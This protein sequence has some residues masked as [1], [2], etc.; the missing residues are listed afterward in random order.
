MKN[1]GFNFIPHGQK[2]LFL[3]RRYRQSSAFSRL[4]A[5]LF[6]TSNVSLLLP[7]SVNAGIS[8]PVK[9][10]AN[11]L[12]AQ[13]PATGT[14][15]FV[16]PSTGNDAATNGSEAAPYKTISFALRQA[17]AGSIIQLAPGN[18][19][20]S[21]GEQFPLNIP[22][23]VTLRGDE[24]SKGQ[25]IQITGGGGYTSRT[26]AAQNIT[27][28]ANN[29]VTIT[30]VTVTNPNQR[31]TAVWVESTNP[32][33]TNN[34]FT[35]SVRDGVFVTGTGNPRVENNL[36]TLNQGNGIS[37]A[38]EARG[39]VRNNVF[40][41]TGFGIAV[42][43][44]A[45]PLISNNQ[46]IGNNGGVVITGAGK[47]VL[48]NN[49][50]QDSRDHG[51]VAI[52][53]G[54]PDLGTEASPGNNLIRN[55]GRQDPKK[56]FDILNA[57]RDRTII[58]VG[59]DVDPSRISGKVELVV[60]KVEPPPPPGGGGT[61]AFRDVPANFW[62]KSY[63]DALAARDIIAGFPG[64]EYRPNEPVTRA[65]FAAII[66]K[67]F[68]PP[69]RRE[70]INFRDVPTSFWGFQAIQTASRGGFLSG[71]PNGTF[72]PQQQI[73][74][75]QAL[76]SLAN[77][78]GLTT[79]GTNVLS[80]YSDANSIPDYA[81]NAIAAATSRS[82]VVNFPSVRQL[83]PRRPAT[84]AEVAAFVY[85]AMVNAGSAPAISSPFIVN[86]SQ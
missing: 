71:Y 16:N 10:S 28:L 77:G 57:T 25:G 63:I 13:A 58:A 1:Q 14:V 46:I 27:I 26:F 66:N 32:T 83:N 44:N 52:T 29:G 38:K 80:F 24:S 64:N 48:R 34:T 45:A 56:Y 3:Q 55:N 84:R 72:Q 9:S 78:L 2:S 59:N 23:N 82:I 35:N 30:G 4:L 40:Q 86:V 73:E 20:S 50:I 85:Q 69:A 74:R 62:A 53:N 15:I 7:I 81:R 31:G 19:D 42:S 17:R 8:T 11:L 41:N 43:E 51:V 18:Y 5:A 49:V 65:Q 60:A 67:A 22:A 70:A 54:E 76:V 39:E 68:N 37:I 75:V 47:P 36:F 12:L 21:N 6:L 33:I 79:T 61:T